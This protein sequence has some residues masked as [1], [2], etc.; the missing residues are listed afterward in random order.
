[1]ASTW[2]IARLVTSCGYDGH[3]IAKGEPVQLHS[4]P[5]VDATRR[6]CRQHAI[7][8]VDEA[9][10][11]HARQ[12]A[13]DLEEREAIAEQAPAHRDRRTPFPVEQSARPSGFAKFG[14]EETLLDFKAAAAGR[15]E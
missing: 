10:I 8:V 13:T 1:M 3:R 2:V 12:A 15:D 5:G 4:L 14:D 11:E 9:A 6:R 7:G